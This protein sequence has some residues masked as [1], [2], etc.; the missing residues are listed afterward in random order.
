MKADLSDLEEY[1][2]LQRRANAAYKSYIH[3][4]QKAIKEERE[5]KWKERWK[6]GTKGQHLR[7]IAEELDR[8]N[9]TL[10]AERA[11]AHNA[12]FTQL[13]TGKIGFNEFLY[14]RRVPE[15]WNE[16]CVYGYTAISVRYVLLSCP[17]WERE[18]EKELRDMV[19]DLKEVLRTKHGATAAIKL[20]LKTSLLEQFKV[21]V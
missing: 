13:R 17:Q 8:K 12:L 4:A 1:N 11:K 2:Y 3:D 10:H 16:R 5:R 7:R 9:R 6:R 20:I 15:I 18:R 14:E 21:T 19:R